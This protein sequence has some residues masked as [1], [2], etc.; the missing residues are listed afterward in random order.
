MDL[1]ADMKTFE[2]P[3]VLSF[4]SSLLPNRSQLINYC[5]AHPLTIQPTSS[6]SSRHGMKTHGRLLIVG[7]THHMRCPLVLDSLSS[8]TRTNLASSQLWI[9][10]PTI[11]NGSFSWE[12][13]LSTKKQSMAALL[14]DVRETKGKTDRGEWIDIK[15][16]PIPL[17]RTV[18]S[19]RESEAP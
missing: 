6:S 14:V 5:D 8:I 12:S 9:I 16:D 2:L 13:V 17:W 15:D 4:L 7:K 11:D 3:E 18:T 10:S 1:C 19:I